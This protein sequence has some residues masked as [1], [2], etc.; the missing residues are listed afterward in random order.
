MKE[1]T[2]VYDGS[3]QFCIRQMSWIRRHDRAGVFEF[4]PSQTP[5]LHSR[6]PKL[7]SEDL[8]SGLRAIDAE[9]AIAVGADAVYQIASRLPYWRRLAWLYRLPVITGLCRWAYAW[10]AARRYSLA[11][12]CDESCAVQVT[13]DETKGVT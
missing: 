6:F 4:V 1:I 10:I 11:G 2:L 9:G 13:R 12:R 5:D 7:A 3:C 8:S